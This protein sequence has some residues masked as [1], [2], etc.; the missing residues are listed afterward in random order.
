M[1]CALFAMPIF[2]L[3]L[4]VSPE[5]GVLLTPHGLFTAVLAALLASGFGT[6]FFWWSLLPLGALAGATL[7]LV[8]A[9]IDGGRS[10][11]P[12]PKVPGQSMHGGPKAG[13]Q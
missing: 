5:P 4:L 8:W 9:R 10:S 11:G 1:A 7:Q 6:L 13:P 12:P 2:L 3:A